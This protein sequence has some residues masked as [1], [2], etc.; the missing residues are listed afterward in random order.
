M[1]VRIGITTSFQEQEQRLHHTYVRA[2]ERAG[3]LPLPVPMLD[4]AEATRAFADLLDGLVITGGPAIVEGLVG[5]LPDDLDETDPI[6]RAADRRLLDAFLETPRPVLGICYGM[7]LLNARA[8]GTLYAD[9]ERQVEGTAVHGAQ[10]GGEPHPITVVPGTHL[11]A[12]LG[13]DVLEVNTRHVQ[14][15][16]RPGDGFRVAARA[17][18]G[19]IEAIED[20]DGR[21]LGVQFHPER[22]GEAMQPLFRHLVRQARRQKNEVPAF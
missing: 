12:L 14:A 16:A 19:T 15:V 1:R 20:E 4:D 11:H 13:A 22:M 7:Q 9:V 6:R 2:V 5:T 8:G 18:D 17:P 10:R 3:G 21:I